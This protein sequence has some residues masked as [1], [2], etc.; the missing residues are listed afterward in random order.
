MHNWINEMSKEN[1]FITFSGEEITLDEEREYLED[2]VEKIN[3]HKSLS[4]VCYVGDEFAGKCDV[5]IKT[6]L[7]KR[8]AHV[9]R[10]GLSI[11]KEFRGEGIGYNL[12]KYTIELV[13]EYLP[14]VKII[15][16]ECFSSN[17]PALNLYK[18]LGFKEIGRIPGA[19]K[20]KDEFIDEVLMYLELK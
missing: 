14:D 8:S 11:A 4:L 12:S 2:L 17:L 1:T 16:L 6:H 9:A 18:K 7:R 5:E 3:N 20:Y 15:E 13:K 10:F 19:I